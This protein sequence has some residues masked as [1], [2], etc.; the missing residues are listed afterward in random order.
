MSKNDFIINSRIWLYRN[1]SFSVM[2]VVII[3]DVAGKV[4]CGARLRRV[5]E[6]TEI[7][8]LGKTGNVSFANCRLAYYLQEIIKHRQNLLVSNP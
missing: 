8:I 4:A 2:R 7:I 1:R 5:S 3:G 6:N